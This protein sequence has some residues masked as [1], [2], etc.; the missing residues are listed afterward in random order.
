MLVKSKILLVISCCAL[1]FLG[2]VAVW[3]NNQ[4]QAA[5][6]LLKG[7]SE[8][9]D[10]LATSAL[11]SSHALPE[12]F[13]LSF[14][15]WDDMANFVTK[16]TKQWGQE[17]LDPSLPQ[18]STD[19]C[20]AVNLD[21]KVVYKASLPGK[22]HVL[23]ADL[24]LAKVLPV[25]MKKKTT[26]FVRDD[27]GELYD[28]SA[29]TINLTNDPKRTGKV[30]GYLLIVNHIDSSFLKRLEKGTSMDVRRSKSKKVEQ[31][32]GY[33]TMSK[34]LIG[35]Q[36]E[37]VGYLSFSVPSKSFGLLKETSDRSLV[38]IALFA[39]TIIVAL[40]VAIIGW[41]NRPLNSLGHSLSASSS[42]P[43][44]SLLSSKNEFGDLARQVAISFEHKRQLEAS[45]DEKT[46]AQEALKMA[47]EHLEER[48]RERTKELEAATASLT[49]ENA[50]RK[51][52]EIRLIEARNAAEAASQTKSRF[53]ANMSHEFR[54][55]LNSVLGFADLLKVRLAEDPK[56][57][58][59]AENIRQSGQRLE[60]LLENMLTLAEGANADPS[61]GGLCDVGD[62]LK[63]I[64]E[65]TTPAAQLKGVSLQVTSPA[66][67]PLIV[68]TKDDLTQVLFALAGNAVKYSHPGGVAELQA[69][70]SPEGDRVQIL[71]SD[72]GIGLSADLQ[73]E[74][75]GSF[76]QAEDS[77]ER[78]YQGA[79]VG[80][81]VAKQLVDR[82]GGKIW[83][84]S[85]GEGKGCVF[86]VS[87]PAMSAHS[88]Q[89]SAA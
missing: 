36:G 2:M 8:S 14:T 42:D 9:Q 57:N 76:C 50:E 79:G 48:V 3:R 29:S 45:I 40:L 21:G 23:S 83:V 26:Q 39:A 43:L 72:Q 78:S 64:V 59:Y 86:G 80:L 51:L 1:L 37:E 56:L 35:L 73:G 11:E 61:S 85:E 74:V 33:L 25:L 58:K 4:Q 32:A 55:P 53:L 18:Y 31:R 44:R 89:S 82:M 77:K 49:V 52:A 27:R 12:A 63:D 62:V 16:P 46:A 54:T 6:T 68:A 71:V 19:A 7:L 13:S 34:P 22:E 66:D 5:A 41:V 70:V 24:G 81:A 69:T 88:R 10:R 60:H 84:E 87:I 65:A 67:L 17:N 28:I 47:N 15:Y 38:T 30:Y 20:F 75:F